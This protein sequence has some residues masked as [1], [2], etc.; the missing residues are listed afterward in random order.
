M[1]WGNKNTAA[2]LQQKWAQNQVLQQHAVVKQVVLSLCA[3]VEAADDAEKDRLVQLARL[4]KDKDVLDATVKKYTTLSP[5]TRDKIITYLGLNTLNTVSSSTDIVKI[6]ASYTDEVQMNESET[7]IVGEY[8]LGFPYGVHQV[9]TRCGYFKQNGNCGHTIEECT[10]L[11][12]HIIYRLPNENVYVIIFRYKTTEYIDGKRYDIQGIDCGYSTY[13][14]QFET[15]RRDVA[16][17][18][19]AFT[20]IVNRIALPD[21]LDR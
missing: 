21:R 4:Y 5:A 3:A 10:N 6:I 7:Q 18:I 15:D 20:R 12:A 13:D 9:Y 8:V 16:C 14:C 17:R 11:L 1:S 2:L 19:G